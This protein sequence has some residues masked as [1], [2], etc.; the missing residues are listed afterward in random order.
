MAGY[1][2]NLSRLP[3]PNVH[4]SPPPPQS[5]KNPNVP[6]LEFFYGKIPALRWADIT[7]AASY[8]HNYNIIGII[9]RPKAL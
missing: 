3:I 7:L 2:Q 4:Y 9:A 5:V 6:P 8:L 1:N